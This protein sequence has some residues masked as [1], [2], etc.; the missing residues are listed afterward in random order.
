LYPGESW[1]IWD[2]G[3]ATLGCVV[4]SS[5]CTHGRASVNTVGQPH[6]QVFAPNQ[7]V[8]QP[9][10]EVCLTIGIS[11]NCSNYIISSNT[12]LSTGLG[13]MQVLGSLVSNTDL[14]GSNKFV[15]GSAGIN[16]YFGAASEPNIPI[17][18]SVGDIQFA[19]ITDMNNPSLT[20]MTYD[21]GMFGFSTFGRTG[22]FTTAAMGWSKIGTFNTLPTII[23]GTLWGVT[24]PTTV[25]GNSPNPGSLLVS[26][27]IVNATF[28][29]TIQEVCPFIS[30]LNISGSYLAPGGVTAYVAGHSA[31][32]PG[33]CT[34]STDT[35][36]AVLNTFTLSLAG[37]D[38]TF[39]VSLTIP[40]KEGG[41]FLKCTA[42]LNVGRDE[43]E[44][45]LLDPVAITSPNG[46]VLGYL[47]G[48]ANTNSGFNLDDWF[49][50][51]TIGDTVGMAIG[52][53][54]VVIIIAVVVSVTV[55]IA[56]RLYDAQIQQG[57]NLIGLGKGKGYE[58][59]DTNPWKG[60]GRGR[61]MNDNLIGVETDEDKVL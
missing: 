2:W 60:K 21:P 40:N 39:L 32:N 52:M 57:L 18:A 53:F 45:N 31:C 46:T 33:T 49:S 16:G 19:T 30:I 44:Y 25:Q 1:C 8:T 41:L 3:G 13:T 42:G 10:I 24:S 6:Y 9:T 51:F 11:S 47:P 48:A 61:E 5:S 17:Q 56:L 54:V 55:V 29:N 14:F 59:P 36:G 34:L 35:V 20:S 7:I 58:I 22:L 37:N 27:S 4:V 28:V 50:D 12:P 23:G 43:K 15:I 38:Q 26:L